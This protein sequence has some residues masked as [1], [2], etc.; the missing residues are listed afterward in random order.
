ME[1]LNRGPFWNTPGTKQ[2]AAGRRKRIGL[3]DQGLA[4]AIIAFLLQ[5]RKSRE[6]LDL[7]G[8]PQLPHLEHPQV[9]SQTR[10]S[11]TGA[12]TIRD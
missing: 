4:K 8:G 11:S 9:V 7:L 1:E 2:R 5:G 3:S 12:G 6:E 10:F